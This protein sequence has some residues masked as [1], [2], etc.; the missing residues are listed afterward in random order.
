[1]QISNTVIL[2]YYL[3]SVWAM[4]ALFSWD[5]QAGGFFGLASPQTCEQCLMLRQWDS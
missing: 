5:W 1:M 2:H 3:I 4:L